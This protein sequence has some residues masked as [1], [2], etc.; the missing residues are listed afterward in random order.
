MKNQL[1]LCLLKGY[2]SGSF[3]HVLKKSESIMNQE[4]APHMQPMEQ[5]E[6]QGAGAN[7]PRNEGQ[8][9]FETAMPNTQPSQTSIPPYGYGQGQFPPYPAQGVQRSAPTRATVSHQC[10]QRPRATAQNPGR[11]GIPCWIPATANRLPSTGVSAV[12][13]HG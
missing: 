3:S 1:D 11:A 4:N 6:E 2:R 9:V 13:P 12:H 7:P 10:N 8:P 5:A